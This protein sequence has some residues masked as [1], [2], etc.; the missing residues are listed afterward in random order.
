MS[1][2]SQDINT[3]LQVILSRLKNVKQDKPN[4]WK[5]CCP[6]HDSKSKSSLSVSL[7]NNTI[8]VNCFA[9]CDTTSVLKAIDTEYKNLF[10]DD[11]PDRI[12]LARYSYT[13]EQDRLLF[14]CIRYLPKG[15]TQCHPGPAG[16]IIWNLKGVRRI[17]YRLPDIIQAINHRKSIFFAEG[18]KDVDNLW[19]KA[20]QPATCNPMGAG[21]WDDSYTQMLK[22]ARE[23]VIIPDNDQPGYDHAR[24]VS[25]ALYSIVS[26]IKI[27]LIP[28]PYK[29]FSE[30][31]ESIPKWNNNGWM[32]YDYEAIPLEFEKLIKT[33]TDYG[34]G[35]RFPASQIKLKV[36]GGIKI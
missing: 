28:G 19:L 25:G 7:I 16:E 14:Y 8:L 6:V 17:L 4:H 15:F 26:N 36:V 35:Y 10:A 32:D 29:D 21:K 9:G 31:M 30:W 27:L 34:P 11:K 5:A 2:I 1:I 20:M 23:I 24:I 12:E 18:E 13:D 33:A 3:N 22:G